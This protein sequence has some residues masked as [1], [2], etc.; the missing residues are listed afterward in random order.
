M[1][2][3][4]NAA[5]RIAGK[6]WGRFLLALSG[7]KCKNTVFPNWDIKKV[8]AAPSPPQKKNIQTLRDNNIWAT[9]GQVTKRCLFLH[10]RSPMWTYDRPPHEEFII[11]SLGLRR[12]KEIAHSL[13]RPTVSH[14]RSKGA[15]ME[16]RERESCIL[17][18]PVPRKAEA[19]Y[20][21]GVEEVASREEEEKKE[22]EV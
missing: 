9:A 2:S 5:G 19:F 10:A 21:P 14:G 13:P 11:F 12:R 20:H 3:N 17:Y 15:K 22:I 16:K 8:V 18:D 6:M 7:K 1:C 4:S